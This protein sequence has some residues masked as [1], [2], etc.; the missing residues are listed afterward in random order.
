M[1][2]ASKSIA[3]PDLVPVRRA[4]LS[5]FD[6]TGLA[7]FAAGRNVLGNDAF[8]GIAQRFLR[9]AGRAGFAEVVHRFFHVA[10]RFDE[11]LFTFHHAHAGH[12][13]KFGDVGSSDFSHK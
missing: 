2:V 13:T 10:L 4:L 1:A 9:R 6:K 3:A 7:G 5:V 11:G 12:F 8:A